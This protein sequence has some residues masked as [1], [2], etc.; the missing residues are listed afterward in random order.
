MS[1]LVLA[2]GPN[3]NPTEH[4]QV[5]MFGLT[6]NTDTIIGTVVSA[7]VLIALALLIRYRLTSGVPGRIQ[8]TF[9]TIT[10]MLADQVESIIGIRL[11]PF[12]IPLSLALFVFCLVA[13]WLTILPL[14][15]G[16]K[17]VMPPPTSDVNFVYPLALLVFIWK[18]IS[19]SRRHGGP[20]GQFLHTV[21][22]H[23]PAFAVMWVIEEIS[24]LVS[25]AL[26]LFGNIFA[27]VIM[28]ELFAL[29]PAYIEWAPNAAWKLFDMFIGLVQSFIFALLTIVYFGQAMENR[30][31]G[32]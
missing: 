20:F 16:T 7:V 29:M 12:L 13:S 11:A 15:V 2:A 32:H 23:F 4:A 1:D 31:E 30:E 10:K 14:H 24:G 5:T 22:G 26:R 27:G 19:G 6:F 25:H 9:E 21:K 8:L 3:I 28:L 18:H 17:S